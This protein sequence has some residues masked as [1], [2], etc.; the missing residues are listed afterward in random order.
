MGIT[1]PSQLRKAA[2]PTTM[3]TIATV[4]LCAVGAQAQWSWTSGGIPIPGSPGLVLNPLSQAVVPENSP[5]WHLEAL[6]GQGLEVSINGAIT[7]KQTPE[8]EAAAPVVKREA[9]AEPWYGWRGFSG[10]PIAG[11]ALVI[12]Q[13]S[14]TP[15]YP[16]AQKGAAWGLNWGLVKREA[17]SEAD[18]YYG[19]GGYGYGGLGYGYGGYGKRSADSE[20]DAYYGYGLG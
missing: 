8:W 5:Q 2:Q 6:R 1:V 14:V 15:D 20:A 16:P 11:G 7:P 13:N 19:Y 17:D 3:K 4:A 9:E 12:G 18:A 10:A